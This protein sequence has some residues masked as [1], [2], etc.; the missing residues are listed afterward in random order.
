[1]IQQEGVRFEL[2][3]PG[4]S[5]FRCFRDIRVQPIPPTLLNIK[6]QKLEESEGF[7]PSWVFDSR[8]LSR[9]AHLPILPTLQNQLL[10]VEN[11][12]HFNSF[13]TSRQVPFP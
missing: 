9:P 13:F 5:R 3:E 1:M 10:L 11:K 8:R 6:F 4:V 2:T 12:R 7:E